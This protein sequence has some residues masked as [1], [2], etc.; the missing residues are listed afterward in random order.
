MTYG[1]LDDLAPRGKLMCCVYQRRLILSH[2]SLLDFRSISISFL[3]YTEWR[4]G[5]Q[6]RKLR[7]SVVLY[8]YTT[9]NYFIHLITWF[10]QGTDKVLWG[11]DYNFSIKLKNKQKISLLE[12]YNIHLVSLEL[13]F[14]L[15]LKK[16]SLICT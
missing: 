7:N 3:L 10:L 15:L 8:K 11:N 12:N 16:I 4:R 13:L 9:L 1:R 14:S 2:V 5:V 6:N